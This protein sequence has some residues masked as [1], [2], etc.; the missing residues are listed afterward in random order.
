M[1]KVV[2]KM[3]PFT[4]LHVHS[5]YSILDGAASVKALVQK[6]KK[7]KMKALALTDHGSMFGIKEFH[8]TCSAEGIKPILGCETYVAARSMKNKS[9]KIDRSGYHLI[10]LA[11]NKTGYRNLIKLVSVANNDGFY[12]KPRID[13]EL[14]KKHSEGL[15]VSSACLGGEVPNLLM[16]NRIKDA[17]EVIQ[18]YKNIF[19][20][21]YYLEIMR[22]PAEAL[23]QRQEVYD[24]QVKVNKLIVPLAKKY[25]IKVIA[26][27]DVH[28]TNAEDADAHDLLICLNTGKDLDD[29]NRMRYT[30]QEWFKTQTEMN[31]LF[32]DI[33]ESLANTEEIES[34][35]EK[36]E[37]N[38]A[39][40][41]P[42][43]PIPKEIGTEEEF[44]AKYSEEQLIEEFGE[45][46]FKRLGGYE[47]VVRV[48]LESAY[49]H[50]LTYNGAKERYGDPIEKSITETIS[51][52]CKTESP[53][54]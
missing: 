5:Q 33:P 19:G 18:W 3:I 44:R 24:N 1:T 43:F 50:H 8:A 46:S 36:F 21:D 30:K 53:R 15:I 25:G 28:F 47:K 6:A 2:E 35:I 16:N 17:E 20:D 32:S 27:N 22:H 11:K 4:H 38:S 42:V 41:M 12:Y 39:P 49:L 23:E 26:T 31:E 10:L 13:K 7:D 40:I 9:E 37:L 14:L 34:K 48:K 45:D 51:V 29:P 52:H 54:K